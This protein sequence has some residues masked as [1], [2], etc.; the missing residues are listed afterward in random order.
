MM[1][2]ARNAFLMGGGGSLPSGYT[3]SAFLRRTDGQIGAYIDTGV[4]AP[5]TGDF[6]AE[7]DYASHRS[8]EY[9]TFGGIGATTTPASK[10]T[11]FSCYGYI[12]Y[13]NINYYVG[14]TLTIGFRTPT[15]PSAV[16]AVF[17]IKDEAEYV[18]ITNLN[19]GVVS[20]KTASLT[21]MERGNAGDTLRWGLTPSAG[22]GYVGYIVGAARLYAGGVVV[23]DGVPCV[24]D[25]DSAVG[26][27]DLVNRSFCPATYGF[28]A[29]NDMT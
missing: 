28:E 13:R 21:G 29:V 18:S 15:S 6:L 5:L 8:S 3:Q 17:G 24:R 12:G 4:Q 23:W 7:I 16:S 14:V 9:L 2:A 11:G 22:L 27:Y 20:S 10:N 25:S 1:I 26:Y 19:T